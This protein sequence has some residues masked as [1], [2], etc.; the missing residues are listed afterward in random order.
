MM[1]ATVEGARYTEPF[2]LLVAQRKKE[3]EARNCLQVRVVW[4]IGRPNKKTIK[5][6]VSKVIAIKEVLILCRGLQSQRDEMFIEL[7]DHPDLKSSGGA[8][9]LGNAGTLRSSGAEESFT[10]T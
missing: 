4:K 6:G 10:A 8:K 9:C 3:K 1:A 5:C 7:R 2:A